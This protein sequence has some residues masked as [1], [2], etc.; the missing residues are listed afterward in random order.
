MAEKKT[1]TGLHVVN[2]AT[3]RHM[4]MAHMARD[5]PLI[6]HGSPGTIKSAMIH[7]IPKWAKANTNYDK[8]IFVWEAM[9]L[10]QMESIDLRGL[11]IVKDGKTI[12]VPPEELPLVESV[13]KRG[14]ENHT[15]LFFVD[16]MGQGMPSVQAAAMQLIHERC[17]GSHKLA[18]NVRIVA[19]TNLASDRSGVNNLLGA[20]ANRAT[21]LQLEPS[22]AEW[23]AWAENEGNIRWEIVNFLRHSEAAFYRYDKSRLVNTTA[24]SWERVS[25]LINELVAQHGDDSKEGSS[26]VTSK[27]IDGLIAAACHGNLDRG[28]ATEFTGFCAHLR[29]LDGLD[30]LFTDPMK[31]P[32]PKGNAAASYLVC[33]YIAHRYNPKA[34]GFGN[35]DNVMTYIGRMDGEF[36]ALAVKDLKFRHKSVFTDTKQYKDW[37]LGNPSFAKQT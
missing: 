23:L 26:I 34:K 3:A 15:I 37:V 31:A 33:G 21:N 18:P 22:C 2:L 6:L 30:K 5:I 29:E 13:K 35:L 27:R 1:E 17:I 7:D 20:L 25:L 19:C 32:L 28:A 9:R 24:R 4:V 8:P 16:E 12:A 10:S 11:T 14:L 36:Q